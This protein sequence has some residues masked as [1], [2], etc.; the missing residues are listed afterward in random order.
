LGAAYGV[1][2]S[3]IIIG[4]IMYLILKKTIGLRLGETLGYILLAYRNIFRIG[5]K[6]L[7]LA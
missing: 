5:R 7:R 6:F 1:V 4:F 3:N 2:L